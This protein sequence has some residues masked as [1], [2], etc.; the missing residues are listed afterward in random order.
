MKIRFSKFLRFLIKSELNKFHEET[1]ITMAMSHLATVSSA[2]HAISSMQHA[3]IYE[4]G[5]TLREGIINTY[6]ENTS[7]VV[8]EFGVFEGKSLNQMSKLLP[9]SKFY[10]FDTFTGLPESWRTGYETGAFAVSSLPQVNSN[11]E[12]VVGLF[13]ETIPQVI[14]KISNQSIELIH[15]DCDLYSSTA[16]VLSL[17]KDLI[18][19][20]KPILIFDEYFNY[21]NWQ[22]HEFKALEEFLIDSGLDKQYIAY[23][24]K[25]QQV[26]VK[27]S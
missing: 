9:N 3:R 8:L 26:A 15:I 14:D 2:E 11:T 6:I 23:T 22:E 27:L 19:R 21:P 20:D 1:D 24:K 13:S 12:L 25:G 7:A 4:S 16:T 17:L 10:G 5:E 18:I